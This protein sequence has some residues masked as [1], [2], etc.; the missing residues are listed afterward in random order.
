MLHP[1]PV[2]YIARQDAKSAKAQR[3]LPRG[4]MWK[5]S[6]SR[7]FVAIHVAI[8]GSGDLEPSLLQLARQDGCIDGFEQA[9]AESAMHSKGRI[10]DPA[11]YGVLCHRKTVYRSPRRQV[12]QGPK[13]AS[14]G[15]MWKLSGSRH[16][17]AIHVAIRGLCQAGIGPTPPWRGPAFS[18]VAMGCSRVGG[19]SSC[20]L[21]DLGVFASDRSGGREHAVSRQARQERKGHLL[22]SVKLLLREPSRITAPTRGLALPIG[23]GFGDRLLHDLNAISISFRGSNGRFRAKATPSLPRG[24]RHAGH[25]VR[26][27]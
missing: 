24:A 5:L 18:V 7:H 21:G 10:H 25:A 6:G 22:H 8:R 11:G 16:F 9:W 12:R 26:R 1:E 19:R 13:G 17:V 20:L 15:R 14:R 27:R 4:R 23:P 3:G 2:Q